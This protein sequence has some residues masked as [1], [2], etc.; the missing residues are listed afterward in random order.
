MRR[1]QPWFGLIRLYVRNM[2]QPQSS[3]RA[4]RIREKKKAKA[5]S[6]DLEEI[7]G[8]RCWIRTSDPIRVKDVLYP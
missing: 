8:G 3:T 4:R 6:L 2:A 7:S 5:I 1:Y